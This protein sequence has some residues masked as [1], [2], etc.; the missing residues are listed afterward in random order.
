[1]NAKNV[2]YPYNG[3]LSGNEK[4]WTVGMCYNMDGPWKHYTKW[5]KSVT[6]RPHILWFHLY[7]MSKIGKSIETETR[8]LAGWDWKEDEEGA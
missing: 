4:E 5:E 7:E 6:K 2:V 3:I 8:L 1:M